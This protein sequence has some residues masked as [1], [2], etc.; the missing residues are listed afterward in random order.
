MKIFYC[1]YQTHHLKRVLITPLLE[2]LNFIYS[3]NEMFLEF[4][5]SNLLVFKELTGLNFLLKFDKTQLHDKVKNSFFIKFLQ[6][7]QV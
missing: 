2:Y 4:Q 3:Q 6:W 7:F 1:I 5:L